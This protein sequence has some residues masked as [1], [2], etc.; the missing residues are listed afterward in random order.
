MSRR[1]ARRLLW[2]GGLTATLMMS[3]WGALAKWTALAATWKGGAGKWEDGAQWGDAPPALK[4]H[5]AIDGD[6]RVTLRRG[7]VVLSRLDLGERPGSDA[8]L[9]VDGGSLM[10]MEHIRVA[11]LTGSHGR[12]VVHSGRLL[13]GELAIAALNEGD[14]TDRRASGEM[15]IRGGD[16]LARYLS[17]GW[18]RGSAADLRVIGSRASRILFLNAIDCSVPQGP[19]GSTC[20]V[21]F[22]IDA[23]GVTPIVLWN[24][25]EAIRLPRPGSANTCALQID[26]LE[27][28]PRGE[29]V[30]FRSA[31]PCLGTFTGL[32]EGSRIRAEHAGTR[33]DWRLT[34]QGGESKADIALTDPHEVTTAK[35]RIPYTAGRPARRMKIA[36]AAIQASMEAMYRE[37]DRGAPPLG[38]GTP[39][40]PGAEGF[41][42]YAR[43]G[44]GG[45]VLFV[46]TLAD[47][48]AGSL[49]AAIEA[50]GPR[51]VIFRV[52][53]TITLRT[54][55]QIREPCLTIA[56]QTAPG[57]GICLRGAADT[58]TLIN[59]HD[60]VVRYLRVR[61]GYTG[62]REQNEGDCISCYS[63]ENFILD[64]CSTSWGTDE[65][66]SVT[67][68]SDR[69]TVQWCLLAEG[70][71]Y[72]GHSYS[73]LL[74]GDRGT[75]HHNLYAHELS[76]NPRFVGLC[77]ADFR[78]N[79]IYDWGHTCG[80]GE[81][82]WVNYVNNYLRRGPA[83]TQ[84]PPR[85]ILG[86]SPA[87]P[88]TLYLQGNLLEGAPE[89]N[90]ENWLGVGFEREVRA[91]RPFA[92][93]PV[94]TQS[95]REAWGRVLKAAGACFPRRDAVDARVVAD[96]R[97]G[98][99]KII[100]R[101]KDLGDW[102]TYASGEPPA[103]ADDDGI[104]DAW[105]TAHGLD[106]HAPPDAA[107]VNADGYTNLEVYLNSL[108][109]PDGVVMRTPERFPGR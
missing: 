47:A 22:A 105:E 65:T 1:T 42:A 13:T 27:A 38:S 103:D 32:P 72:Y 92:A 67:E 59:T 31:R 24:K 34:Y 53:G 8:A 30:L 45:R 74:G 64:H 15:E 35:G 91:A 104:P 56:G 20:R 107:L 46:T 4:D 75:W 76:R 66:I 50:R 48:G 95:A 58:L 89:V 9:I 73:S 94:E 88:A 40:F 83:T 100:A 5:V 80:Y 11:E 12:L 93:P 98:T 106:P 44:R 70:L 25:K 68:S 51:T 52:G 36:P 39:A 17:L 23:G 49:R 77:R 101:E 21:S 87:L 28:P 81:F 62:D 33:Y 85:F 78:N 109:T 71:N 84:N 63:A 29:I 96:T 41:G 108:V 19:V 69:Y 54:P 90:A 16:V 6:S 37:M 3:M 97:N 10:A 18:G 82:R 86:E 7:R 99:G 102:P 2:S 61:T 79:V 57:D 26:L 43:G 14:G 55:L 60:V